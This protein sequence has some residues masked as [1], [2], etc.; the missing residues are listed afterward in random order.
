MRMSCDALYTMFSSA[1]VNDSI[2]ANRSI[3]L[4]NEIRAR[5][6]PFSWLLNDKDA[7]MIVYSALQK[8]DV[9]STRKSDSNYY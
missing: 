9:E 1:E 3:L 8:Y 2:M 4:Y 6:R 5:D 7:S